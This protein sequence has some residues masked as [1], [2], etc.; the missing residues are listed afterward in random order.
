MT[1]PLSVGGWKQPPHA[2]ASR[3]V[4]AT[5]ATVAPRADASKTFLMVTLFSLCLQHDSARAGP[6]QRMRINSV[7]CRGRTRLP[8]HGRHGLAHPL[9][10]AEAWKPRAMRWRS[11]LARWLR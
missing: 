7:V 10:G 8:R 6:A 1:V 3:A 2:W 4:A 5:K 9:G 11:S